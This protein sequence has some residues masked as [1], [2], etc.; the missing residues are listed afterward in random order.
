[1]WFERMFEHFMP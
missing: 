1:M